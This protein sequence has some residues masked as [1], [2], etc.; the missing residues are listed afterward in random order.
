MTTYI[1]WLRDITLADIALV[2]GR[3][4]PSASSTGASAPRGSACPTASP[5]PRRP[6]ARCW[7]RAASASGSP[8]MLDGVRVEDVVALAAAGAELRRLVE[9]APLP[10][11]LD[12]EVRA[13]YRTLALPDGRECR[14]RRPLERDGRGSARGELRRPAREL[15]QRARGGGR[16]STPSGAAS[17]R[18]SPTARSST[19]SRTGFDH[20]AVLLSVG[21]QKMV[22]RGRRERRR[23]LH[24]RPG[25]RLPRRRARQR[26][27]R[28]RRDRRAGAA[29][30]RRVPG[31]SSRRFAAAIGPCSSARSPGKTWKLDHGRAAECPSAP[32]YLADA[33]LAPSLTD[34]EAL[35]LGAVGPRDRGALLEGGR[36][37]DA[38]WTSSG[39]R[40]ARRASSSSCRRARRRCTGPRDGPSSRSSRSR[41]APGASG[42]S[43][44]VAIGQRIGAGP[45]A[46][47][48]D[49]RATS[50]RSGRARCSWRR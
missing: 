17:P 39:P 4:P 37:R 18:S 12:D 11:G 32:R 48:R 49:R 44:G 7:T 42:S 1:R 50:P 28:P 3:P 45:R 26:R 20:L 6:I 10:P 38:R 9:E 34:D 14:R 24:A 47:L 31:S 33:Q 8:P 36:T 23:H 13:A 43:A 15:P 46:R 19:A 25:D 2:G 30:S 41:R 16:S 27:L 35:A 5:S 29:R 40:T 21:V 22:R